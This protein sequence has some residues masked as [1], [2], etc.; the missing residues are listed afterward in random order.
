LINLSVKKCRLMYRSSSFKRNKMPSIFN[1]DDKSLKSAVTQ[2]VPTIAHFFI[3]DYRTN[4]PHHLHA[5]R[6][7]EFIHRIYIVYFITLCQSLC[8]FRSPDEEN[9]LLLTESHLHTQQEGKRNQSMN[10]PLQSLSGSYASNLCHLYFCSHPQSSLHRFVCV[11]LQRKT[12]STQCLFCKNLY[13][14]LY[15]RNKNL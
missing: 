2:I 14:N 9:L 11:F 10:I 13:M 1:Q 12:Q 8:Q 6:I 4:G 15:I 7:N 5:L 3:V